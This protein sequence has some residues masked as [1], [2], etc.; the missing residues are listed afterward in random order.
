MPNTNDILG[1]PRF[2]HWTSFVEFH[3]ST[4]KVPS[5]GPKNIVLKNIMV[6]MFGI[7]IG[8]TRQEKEPKMPNFQV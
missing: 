2:E 1:V 3:S 4:N 7:G 8:V 5:W 6:E